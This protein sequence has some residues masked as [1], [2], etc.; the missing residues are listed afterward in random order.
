MA[1][2]N[3]REAQEE[4]RKLELAAE[5]KELRKEIDDILA[6]GVGKDLSI[7]INH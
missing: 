2:L 1:V 3:E 6:K 7:G 4:A 5:H